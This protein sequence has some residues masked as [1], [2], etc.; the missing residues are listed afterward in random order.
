MPLG[1]SASSPGALCALETK[2]S[3]PSGEDVQKD[4]P[5]SI[6]FTGHLPHLPGDLKI[7]SPAQGIL[8]H[9]PQTQRP[10]ETSSSSSGFMGPIMSL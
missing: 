4:F 7:S 10:M 9:V 5:S 3:L 8:G 6:S 2:E 1:C